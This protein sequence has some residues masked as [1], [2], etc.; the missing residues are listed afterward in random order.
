[1][2]KGISAVGVALAF[3][4]LAFAPLAFAP[5]ARAQFST[6]DLAGTWSLFARFDDPVM[7]SPGETRG[8]LIL[9]GGGNFSGGSLAPLGFPIETVTGG[10]LSITPLGDVSGTLVTSPSGANPLDALHVDLAGDVVVGTDTDASGFV[11]LLAAVRR[12]GAFSSADFAGNWYLFTHW[13][14]RLDPHSPGWT[15]A[16]VVFDG[17]GTVTSTVSSIE[18]DGGSPSLVGFDF[19]ITAGGTVTVAVPATLADSELQMTPDK[20][21]IIGTL[22]DTED[23]GSAPNFLVAIRV[24]AAPTTADLAGTW[25]HYSFLDR[26]GAND[27]QWTRSV[28]TL[29]ALGNAVSGSKTDSDGGSAPL[30]GGSLAVDAGGRV[31]GTLSYGALETDRFVDAKLN[32]SADLFAGVANG[33]GGADD[34]R[35]L[36]V[37]V[38]PEPGSAAVAAALLASL[39]ALGRRRA[40]PRD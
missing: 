39:G 23:Q 22:N 21:T 7:N 27:P 16:E 26:D 31:D 1:M 37:A 24:G 4:A 25:Y 36:S 33:A 35:I 11:S 10:A 18:S 19:D 8:T 28:F 9:D 17:L 34:R 5:D 30:S 29:D 15:R 12:E 3:A 6:G 32:A 14:E 13:D 20:Q 40:T 38:L 2:R